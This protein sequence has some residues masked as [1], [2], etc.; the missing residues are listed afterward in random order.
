MFSLAPQCLYVID[1]AMITLGIPEGHS[2]HS[3]VCDPVHVYI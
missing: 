2:S 3:Y 1:V